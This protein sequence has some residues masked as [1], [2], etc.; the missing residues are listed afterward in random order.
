MNQLTFFADNPEY[1]GFT[2]KFE[3]KKTTDDCYTP[4]RVYEAVA[5]WVCG[6]Y[7]VERERFVRPFYPGGDYQEENYPDD[8]VVV[9]NPPF[10]IFAQIL[11]F[12]TARGIRFFLFGPTLTLFSARG[13]EGVCY[14]PVG[15]SVTYDNGANVNTS[16]VTNLDPCRVRTAPGLYAAVERANFETVHEGKKSLPRYTYPPDIITSTMAARWTKYGVDFR[17]YPSECLRIDALDAMGSKSKGGKTIFGGG[18]LLSEAAAQAAA[19]AAADSYE[20]K[21]SPREKEIQNQ[22]GKEAKA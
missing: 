2:K 3:S 7:G 22:L 14:I 10:S 12:Y 8:C 11:R 20:W 16:F 17:L 15:V 6:E 5:G 1:D 19:Q 9:D 13:I 4:E 18:F 21:L